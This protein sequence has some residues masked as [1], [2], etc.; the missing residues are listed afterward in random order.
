MGSTACVCRGTAA[1]LSSVFLYS[2]LVC[3]VH[4]GRALSEDVVNR[5]AAGEIIHRPANALKE[6]VENALDAGSTRIQVTLKEGGLKL[7]QVQDDGGGIHP[8]DFKILCKRFTT[9]KLKEFDDLAVIDTFGFRGEALASITHVAHV[10]IL[11]MQPGSTLAY[12]AK[13]VDGVMLSPAAKSSKKSDA[14]D[15]PVPC[16]GVRGTT[17]VVEDLFFNTQVRT[18]LFLTLYDVY[19]ASRVSV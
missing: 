12:K 18:S 7:L 8:A 4:V 3:V 2:L 5:I 17:I 9:S 15:E 19:D 11:S 10:S 14:I 13:Y 6:L 16:A 1:H